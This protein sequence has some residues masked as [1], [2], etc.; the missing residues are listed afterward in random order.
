MHELASMAA[1]KAQEKPSFPPPPAEF[2]SPPSN[3]K[4]EFVHSDFSN[5]TILLWNFLDAK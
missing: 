4:V 3:E 5:L 2:N 1:T